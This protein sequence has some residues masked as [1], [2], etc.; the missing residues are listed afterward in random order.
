MPQHIVASDAQVTWES[1]TLAQGPGEL[2][3]RLTR[4]AYSTSLCLAPGF[5][6]IRSRR[7]RRRRQQPDVRTIVQRI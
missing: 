2:A 4:R 3:M 6:C 5:S 1:D 7:Q